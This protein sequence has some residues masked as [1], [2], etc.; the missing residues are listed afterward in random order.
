MN[1][2]E[3][4]DRN[5]PQDNELRRV[6]LVHSWQVA[7]KALEL[8]S[9]HPELK[10]NKKLLFEGAMVHDLGIF[11]THAPSIYCE[12]E[13]D[14]LLHG[15]LGG[16]LL[17]EEGREDLARICERHTGTGLNAEDFAKR[18]LAIPTVGL[19]PVTLEEK[20]VCYAD[21]YYSKSSLYKLKTLDA[22]VAGLQRHGEACA[23]RF[24]EWHALFG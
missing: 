21:K 9:R 22:I 24:L 20:A 1:V 2:F 10:L 5:Y 7:G 12:G 3:L 4:I 18:H 23:A 15:C 8:A 13:A 19:E 17:R 11:K 14:Y 16:A 6:L